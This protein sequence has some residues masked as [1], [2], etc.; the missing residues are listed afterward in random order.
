MTFADE[1]RTRAEY[2]KKV[3]NV[4]NTIRKELEVVADDGRYFCRDIYRLEKKPT[5]QFQTYQGGNKLDELILKRLSDMGLKCEINLLDL[6]PHP[7]VGQEG[8]H[9]C[10]SVD[11]S[12]NK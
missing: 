1:L 9:A 2:T 12:W 11:V 8:W 6:N 5:S 7:E 4:I 10:Y 3:N